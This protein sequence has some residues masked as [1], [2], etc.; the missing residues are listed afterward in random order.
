MSRP[1]HPLLDTCVAL[2]KSGEMTQAEA[3]RAYKVAESS[4]SRALN[5]KRCRCCGRV[6]KKGIDIPDIDMQAKPGD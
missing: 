5:A 6:L 4:I 3:S 2:V 1:K